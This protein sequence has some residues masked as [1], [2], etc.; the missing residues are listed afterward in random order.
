M[1]NVSEYML[2]LA[3]CLVVDALEFWFVKGL[4]GPTTLAGD[5]MCQPASQAYVEHIL[6]RITV[7]CVQ[8][9][10]STDGVA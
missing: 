8:L 4:S 6:G 5:L 2:V 10:P 7:S 1:Q 9:R 3:L